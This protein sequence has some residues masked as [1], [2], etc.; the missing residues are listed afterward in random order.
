MLNIDQLKKDARSLGVFLKE[1]GVSLSHGACLDAIARINNHKNWHTLSALNADKTDSKEE[2][3]NSISLSLGSMP[4]VGQDVLLCY[5]QVLVAVLSDYDEATS[6]VGIMKALEE[7]NADPVKKSIG[8]VEQF[9]REKLNDELL[10]LNAPFDGF[11][12]LGLMAYLRK[13]AKELI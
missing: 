4:G 3:L 12:P 11:T 10:T 13:K 6:V 8:N 9:L 5:K 1:K 2:T 7:L